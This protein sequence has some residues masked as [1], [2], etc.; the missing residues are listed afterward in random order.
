MRKAFGGFIIIL[1]LFI[2]TSC[3]QFF[4]DIDDVFGY[5]SSSIR[6]A[7]VE[8]SSLGVDAEGY[9]CIS[10]NGDK[11]IKLKLINPQQY[12]LKLPSDQD[13]PSDIIKFEDGVKGQ[14]EGA[15]QYLKDY[16]IKQVSLNELHLIYKENFLRVSKFGFQ[17]LSPT[18]NLYNCYGIKFG[19]HTFKLRC[20]TPPAI[21]ESYDIKIGKT[22]GADAYYVFCFNLTKSVDENKDVNAVCFKVGGKEYERKFS[23]SNEGAVTPY[24]ESMTGVYSLVEKDNVTFLLPAD[25]PSTAGSPDSLPTGNDVIFLKTDIQVGASSIAKNSFEIWLKDEKGLKSEKRQ[26]S[27]YSR[28]SS[29]VLPPP[30]GFADD[31]MKDPIN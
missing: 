16:E 29:S 7:D 10:S 8:I 13:A 25:M 4:L 27:T 14:D 31:S 23:I 2:L 20:N 28:D 22:K 21:V 12:Q 9:P 24:P 26:K 3:K 5:W 30:T 17:N 18:I 6:I 11:T 19:S 15:P 1:F